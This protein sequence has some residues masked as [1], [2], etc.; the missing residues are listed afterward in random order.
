M[1]HNFKHKIIPSLIP[2]FDLMQDY[3]LN[4]TMVIQNAPRVDFI[5]PNLTRHF[6]HTFEEIK[7]E[8]EELLINKM[9]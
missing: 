5:F 3:E 9:G 8:I 4:Q 2:L 7:W 6:L 1:V